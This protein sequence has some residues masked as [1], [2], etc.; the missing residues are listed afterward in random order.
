MT[1]PMTSSTIAPAAPAQVDGRRRA[2]TVAVGV[3]ALGVLLGVLW[4][5]AAP[6]ARA[7]VVDGQVY[8]TGHPELQVAQDGWFAAVTGLTGVLA[9]TIASLRPSREDAVSAALGPVLGLVVAVVA[10]QTGGLLGPDSLASQVAA[11]SSHPLTP[12]QLHAYGALL[13]GPLLFTVT[14]FLATLFSAEPAS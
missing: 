7:D 10:W 1:H 6:L 9:A 8:L 13:V 14:R 3:L 2:A 5:V 4:W 12:L 11:G